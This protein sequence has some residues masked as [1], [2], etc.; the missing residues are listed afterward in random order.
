VD[1][2]TLS[3]SASGNVVH[4][5]ICGSVVAT[6]GVTVRSGCTTIELSGAAKTQALTWLNGAALT[7]WK[8]SEGL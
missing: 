2:A 8:N 4:A 5:D 6:D 1:R 3:I 7:A